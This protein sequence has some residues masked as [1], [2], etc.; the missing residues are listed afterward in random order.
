MHLTCMCCL[1]L[2]C[3]LS[4][5]YAMLCADGRHYKHYLLVD[6]STG[7]ERLAVVGEDTARLDRRYTY[8]ALD[9]MGGFCFENGK[10]VNDWLDFVVGKTNELP[11][12][13]IKRERPPDRR[14]RSN[15]GSKGRTAAGGTATED[16]L[17]SMAVG[18][19]YGIPSGR[20]SKG[21]AAAEGR[22]HMDAIKACR[23]GLRGDC[24]VLP[25]VD[26]ACKA[27]A[28]QALFA[29]RRVFDHQ[30]DCS[31]TVQQQSR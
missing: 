21:T 23:D 13:F 5:T 30:H 31:A 16:D 7:A 17:E 28:L 12:N 4:Y 25:D 22:A 24:D 27:L 9:D 2:S 6:A 10:A 3:V 11:A 20:V 19:A 14:S 15:K 29:L 26:A 1:V 18:V 8:K